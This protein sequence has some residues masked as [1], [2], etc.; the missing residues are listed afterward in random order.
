MINPKLSK[1]NLFWQCVE[2]S[3]GIQE[4]GVRIQNEK[5]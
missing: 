3:K 2:F 5:D 4:S 1:S